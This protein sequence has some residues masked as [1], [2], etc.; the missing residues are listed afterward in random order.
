MSGTLFH[1]DL[2]TSQRIL[3]TPSAFA[4]T[5]LVHLQEI[6]TLEARQ[7]HISRRDN[8]ASYLFFI[9]KRGAGKLEYQG[10]RF[11]LTAGD[12]VF[13]DC[14]NGYS[15][16][17]S[18]HLWTLQW[19]HFFGPTVSGIYEKYLERGGRAIF[20]PKTLSV[21][22][23]RLDQLYTIA[24]STDYLRDM[25]INEELTRLLTLLMA[26]S[27]HPER[28]SEATAKKQSLLLVRDYLDQNFAQKITLDHL[29]EQFFM[30]KYYLSHMFKEQ[31]GVTVV[32]HL[33]NL[34]ITHAKQLLRFSSLT[35]EAVGAAC[36]MPD[37][38]YFSRV[39]RKLEGIS[40]SEYRRMW[41][42]K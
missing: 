9:V 24:A 41:Q 2:V 8:L 36:G 25:R 19:V 4:K 42:A 38:N 28:I 3:Y 34:R 6:G 26:E 27:W 30:N 35:A 22:E 7:P 1:G 12:C 31:F 16:A 5:N 14:K 40:P 15:H 39:F 10:Q 13:I 17:T 18:Q 11:D 32:E 23:S 20:H 33:S 37:A 29:A 21:F